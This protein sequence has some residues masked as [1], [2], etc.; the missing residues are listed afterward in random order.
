M[1]RGPFEIQKTAL[2]TPTAC[3]RARSSRPSRPPPCPRGPTRS[4]STPPAD[5]DRRR[6]SAAREPAA[7]APAQP[8]PAA[9]ER[10]LPPG[11]GGGRSRRRPRQRQAPP[12][13]GPAI[14]QFSQQVGDQ[15]G[16]PAPGGVASF[17]FDLRRPEFKD[18]GDHGAAPGVREPRRRLRRAAVRPPG[19]ARARRSP[20]RP[21]PR[22]R[23]S[24]CAR[25]RARSRSTGIP[26]LGAA[27][28][29]TSGL[30]NYGVVVQEQGPAGTSACPS[31]PP[32]PR[33][34]PRPWSRASRAGAPT[35]VT[36]SAVAHETLLAAGPPLCACN[37]ATPPEPGSTCD[38]PAVPCDT[39]T[40]LTT[41]HTGRASAAII[42]EAPTG[43]HE[44]PPAVPVH[45]GRPGLAG[46]A[47]SSPIQ[48]E[49]PDGDP[50]VL[51]LCG[52]RTLDTD[53]P[54]T[55]CD[56]PSPPASHRRRRASPSP[57]TAAVA[58]LSYYPHARGAGPAHKRLRGPRRPG[59]RGH[60]AMQPGGRELRTGEAER[61]ITSEP[62]R[63]VYVGDTFSYAIAVTGLPPTIVP[64]LRGAP[65]ARRG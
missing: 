56:A 16:Y 65:R 8:A 24:W 15:E 41:E 26:S 18:Q 4:R 7:A 58:L 22:S 23:A 21:H 11:M 27:C 14:P 59:W 9:R 46:Q 52:C 55:T 34:P 20:R 29:R 31:P 35:D 49:D 10:P 33:G 64:Q 30:A 25:G 17:D 1:F 3:P 19:L 13:H 48:V 47:Y 63:T 12:R 51:E 28:S 2:T 61:L 32:C 54:T 43:A 42:F 37:P 38:Q 5:A 45:A 53:P 62:P 50:L 44:Q 57:P 36:V 39:P 6:R 40:D 60:T